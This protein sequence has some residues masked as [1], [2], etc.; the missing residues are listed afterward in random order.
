[1]GGTIGVDSTPGAGS[2]FWFEVPLVRGDAPAVEA[3]DETPATAARP[4]R[5]L[6][7]DDAEMNRRLAQFMLQAAGHTVETAADGTAAVEA[8]AR[9]PFDVVL[10][11]VQMPGMDGYE[12]ARQI[13]RLPAG[14]DVPVIAMTANVMREDVERCFDAG[15]D[16]HISKPIDKTELLKTVGH[17]GAR[18]AA[19]SAGKSYARSGDALPAT[20]PGP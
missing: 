15:M 12:A 5:V 20:K 1:M 4:L 18:R 6:L 7:V 8:A 16:A 10:M 17:W 13:R 19:G 14:S 11:D 3:A 2:T 9:A